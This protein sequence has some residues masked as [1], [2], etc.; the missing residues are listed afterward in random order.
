MS[1]APRFEEPDVPD[2]DELDRVAYDAV[3]RNAPRFGR[4]I[5]TGVGIGALAGLVIGLVL[6]N[7]TAVGRGVVALLVAAGFALIGGLVASALVVGIDRT[8]KAPQTDGFPWDKDG[9]Q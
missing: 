6:P 9:A 8:S 5:G 3:V 4:F 2:I 1:D 7:T